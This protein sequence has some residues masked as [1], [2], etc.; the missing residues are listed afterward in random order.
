MGYDLHIEE[1]GKTVEQWV[2]YVKKSK[3]LKLQE[4]AV[5]KNP[6]TG[7]VIQIGTPNGAIG[8]NGIY[9]VS[10]SGTKKLSITINSPRTEDIPYLKEITK[11][12][13]GVLVG[14]EGEK[15]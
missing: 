1:S 10:R 15:Y 8:K 14:D 12:F 3:T 7:E 13:G 4:V 2:E 5:A 11:E 9:F 6:H